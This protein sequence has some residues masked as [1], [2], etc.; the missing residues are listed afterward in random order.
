VAF[1]RRARLAEAVAKLA[2]AIA[3]GA[4]APHAL[5]LQALASLCED[6]FL[7]RE[8]ARVRRWAAA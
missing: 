8:A 4:V 6:H 3:T 1:A 5:E 7:P 2:M